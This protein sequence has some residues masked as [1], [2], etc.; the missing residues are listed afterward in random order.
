MIRSTP[1]FDLQIHSA[2][3]AQNGAV[4]GE[5]GARI[6][7]A[8]AGLE[9]AIENSKRQL[10]D[11]TFVERAPEKVVNDLRGKLSDYEAQLKKNRELL[12][13]LS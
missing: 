3:P 11:P 6:E 7:K 10:S 5:S 2:A 12:E 9:R 1:D 8:I 4:G 13:G